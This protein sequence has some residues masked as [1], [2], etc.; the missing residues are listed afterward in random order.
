MAA[1][2]RPPV[3]VLTALCAVVML[4][5]S[6]RGQNCDLYNSD[7]IERLFTAGLES[8][9]PG[10]E[11]VTVFEYYINCL[12]FGRLRNKFSFTTVTVIFNSSLHPGEEI[13]YHDIGCTET[14]IWDITPIT[15]FQGLEIGRGRR[16][17]VTRMDC[18]ACATPRVIP[19]ITIGVVFDNATHC[20][21][22]FGGSQWKE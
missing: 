18:A 20:Y 22:T 2:D 15:P 13:A 6:A 21:G 4:L 14:N 17:N 16:E 12:S 5:A 1:G 8:C 9:H 3:S 11:N 7:I 10:I 19:L